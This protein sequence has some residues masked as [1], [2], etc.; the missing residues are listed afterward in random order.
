MPLAQKNWGA[1]SATPTIAFP[2]KLA[3]LKMQGKCTQDHLVGSRDQ[4]LFLKIKV[5]IF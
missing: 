4:L 1:F 5:L 3:R 2:V